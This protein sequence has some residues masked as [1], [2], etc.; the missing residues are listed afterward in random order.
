MCGYGDKVD[1]RPIDPPPIIQ[2]IVREHGREANNH[3]YNPYFFMYATLSAP[4]GDEELHVLKDGKTRATSGT[5]VSSLYR[6]KDVDQSDAAFFVFP[7]LSV[8]IEGNY[9]LKF[10]LFEIEG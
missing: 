1:R 2:V 8:R 6:L 3:L 5:I 7:D 4:E 9:R 10:S